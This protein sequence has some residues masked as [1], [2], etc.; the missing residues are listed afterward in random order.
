MDS[1]DSERM[2]LNQNQSVAALA[3]QRNRGALSFDGGS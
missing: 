3:Q 2:N 1:A